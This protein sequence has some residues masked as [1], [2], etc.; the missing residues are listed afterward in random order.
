MIIRTLPLCLLLTAPGALA[1][2]LERLGWL[3]GHWVSRDGAAEEVWLEPRGGTMPGSFR[4]VF[5]NGRQVLEYLVIEEAGDEVF[6]RFKHF[7]TNF[8]PWEKDEPNSYRLL[9][10]DGQQ[11]SFERIGDNPKVPQ[12]LRYSRDGSTLDF[13]GETEGD[14]EPL[15]LTFTL[16]E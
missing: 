12:Y 16:R 13:R 10:L 3:S 11:A 7:E 1:S 6:L 9:S 2:E 5:P 14:D 4:W 8:E 15:L